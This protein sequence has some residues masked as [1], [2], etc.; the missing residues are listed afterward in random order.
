MTDFNKYKN[1][2]L[3]LDVYSKIQ[4]IGKILVPDD[5][6]ISRAQVVT[7]LVNKE[8]KKLNGRLKK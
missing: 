5:P 2:S 7:I 6:N 8:A 1:I 3:K 4:K